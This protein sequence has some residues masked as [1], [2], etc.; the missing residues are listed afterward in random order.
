[1]LIRGEDSAVDL[2]STLTEKEKWH[3][4]LFGYLVLRQV[5]SPAEVEK[6]LEVAGGWFAD[7]EA[8]P[9]PVNVTQGEYSGV[10][11]NVQYG[12]RIFERLSLNEKVMRIVMGLMWNRPRLFNCALVLCRSNAPS[13]KVKRRDSI[14]TPV[15]LNFLMDSIIHTMTT[16]QGTDRSTAI[17]SIP[18]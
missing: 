8:A 3:Y 17:S 5:V 9:E 13:M 4:D 2:P 18:P 16:K 7:P 15:V 12:D 6:M 10:L 14:G 1:M 11:N